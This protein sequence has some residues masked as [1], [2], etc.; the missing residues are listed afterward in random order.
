MSLSIA[1]RLRAMGVR[2]RC[3]AGIWSMSTRSGRVVFA[4]SLGD[5]LIAVLGGAS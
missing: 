3:E 4:G 5:C 2:A 1:A